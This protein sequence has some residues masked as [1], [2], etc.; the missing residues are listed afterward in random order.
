MQVA[1]LQYMFSL[2]LKEQDINVLHSTPEDN[3]KL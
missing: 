3:L 1:F 2:I